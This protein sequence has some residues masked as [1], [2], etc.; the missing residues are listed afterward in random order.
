[1]SDVKITDRKDLDLT[2][3]EVIG[4][5]EPEKLVSLQKDFINNKKTKN[6]IF[7]ISYGGMNYFSLDDFQS[8]IQ[9]ARA[10]GQHRR[11]GYT[12]L[13]ANDTVKTLLMGL[14]K[15]QAE[16]DPNFPVKYH[17]TSTMADALS[18]IEEKFKK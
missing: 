18:Y 8:I 5:L 1:M 13:I 10:G 17:I 12:V 4:E 14:Y 3:Y 9:K 2:I 6:A 11:G 15:D 16:L 7:D